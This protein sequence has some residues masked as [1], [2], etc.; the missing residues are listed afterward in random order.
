[1]AVMAGEHER[2]DLVLAARAQRP[3]VHIYLRL[4][5]QELHHLV[6]RHKSKY[7]IAELQFHTTPT[8][9]GKAHKIFEANNSL[10]H[11][12]L[13]PE[14]ILGMWANCPNV[15]SPVSLGLFECENQSKY[16]QKSLPQLGM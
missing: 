16:F 12:L 4:G 10:S 6:V 14:W 8:K 1:M 15:G 5:K 9:A 3:D 2:G 11:Y 13:L 7:S